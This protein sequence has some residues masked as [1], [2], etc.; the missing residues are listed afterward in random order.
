MQFVKTV[1]KENG[2]AQVINY[3]PIQLSGASIQKM[4]ES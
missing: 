4:K 1:M 2:L 3:I